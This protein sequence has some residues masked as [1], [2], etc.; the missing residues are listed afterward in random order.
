MEN[1]KIEI[2]KLRIKTGLSQS[3]FAEK[4]GIPKATLQDWEHKRRNPRYIVNLI[5]EIL[6]K[7]EQL[8]HVQ[9]QLKQS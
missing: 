2:Q 6:E 3:K 4:F 7:E 5:N 8:E 9:Q 1:K